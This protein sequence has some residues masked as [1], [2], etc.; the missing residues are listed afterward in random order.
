MILRIIIL[1]KSLLARNIF[2][3]NILYNLIQILRHYLG[4]PRYYFNLFLK[5]PYIGG[6]L[7]TKQEF[8]RGRHNIIKKSLKIFI[9]NSFNKDKPLNILEIGSYAGESTL[10]ICNFLK[11][12]N[13]K[14]FT[15]HCV[16]LWDSFKQ[17]QMF[18]KSFIEII[19]NKSLK[20]G[21]IYK[22]FEQNIFFSGYKNNIKILKGSSLD[23][24]PNMK[25]ISF[26][27]IYIDGAHNY[28]NVLSD[29]KESIK[30][31]NSSGI[32]AGDDYELT[33][34]ECDK[35]DLQDYI[36]KESLDYCVDKKT[37]KIYHPGVTKAVYD[38]FGNIK[39]YNGCWV[40]QKSEV[41][42]NS[43]YLVN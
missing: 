5:K 20:N 36:L 38:I 21:K 3:W 23:I 12:N 41:V 32:I 28:L 9:E 13:I 24:L 34:S 33:Y 26:D 16:D 40:Q 15:I 10:M 2:I 11:K 22:I 39:S 37:K 30:L 35:K 6:Y 43:I 14:N 8:L 4:F 29:I 1:F 42:F 19:S 18:R 31:L 25:N 27:F 7:F 17:E